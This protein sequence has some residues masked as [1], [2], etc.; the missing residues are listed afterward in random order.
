M[1]IATP[2]RARHS[3]CIGVCKLDDDTGFCLGCGR[4]GE[5]IGA[6]S[7][8][9][10]KSRDVVWQRLPDRVALLSLR[11]HLLPW[12]GSDIF[13][14]V[15]RTIVDRMG[16]WV[17][18]MPGALAEFPCTAGREASVH[19][20]PDELIGRADDSQF[21]LRASDRLRAFAF[22]KG[23]P[24]VIGFSRARIDDTPAATFT[25]LGADVNAIDP[26]NASDALYDFGLARRFSRF[27]IRTGN[28]DFAT[29]LNG[30]A[31]LPWNEVFQQAGA[32]ILAESPA[33]IVESQLC[34][35]EVYSP[36]P[37]PGGS[38]PDGAHTHFL[39]QFIAL[40]EEIPAGLALPDYAAPVAIFYPGALPD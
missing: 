7:G 2:P 22:E 29:T 37:P 23:G 16:T 11:V 13:E 24:I 8:L 36:I 1:N 35:I 38:S 27:C 3:P 26:R 40:G 32:R 17:T 33:R 18:G 14:W 21:R 31:G 30:L 4:T 9:D 10:E 39:P 34:R 15:G 12:T 6:W 20:A 19:M 28:A 5:E 25:P